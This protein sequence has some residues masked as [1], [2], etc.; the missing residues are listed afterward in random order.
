MCFLQGVYP[1]LRQGSEW[2][3]W[4]GIL[5][6][7]SADSETF[8]TTFFLRP[9]E[10]SMGP[11]TSQRLRSGALLWA[12]P[13]S[14]TVGPQAPPFSADYPYDGNRPPPPPSEA[15]SGDPENSLLGPRRTAFIRP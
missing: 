3:F 12:A 14:T 15:D 8:E 5:G 4:R 7:G 10:P 9:A 13:T 6:T 11:E 2:N 1:D